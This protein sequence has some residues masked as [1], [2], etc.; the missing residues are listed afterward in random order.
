MNDIRFDD[1]VAIITGA[2]NGL[3]KDY[4]LSLSKLGAAVVVNDL[5]VDPV[6]GGGSRRPADAVVEEI[7]A[8]GGR[9]IASYDTV[10]TPEGG[11]AIAQSAL[12]AFGKVDILINN[13]AIMTTG[14]LTDV[15]KEDLDA[16]LAVHLCGSFYVTQPCFEVMQARGYG[17]LLFVSSN[18][19][20]FGRMGISAYAAAKAGVIG[21]MNV[22]A[23]EG[24]PYGIMSNAL[25]PSAF[26]RQSDAYVEDA[27]KEVKKSRATD[28]E[29]EVI[30]AAIEVIR[31]SMTPEFVTPMALYLCSE[32][33]QISHSTFSAVAGRY[34]R[35]FMGLTRGWTASDTAP[36]SVN[37]IASH[38]AAITD[39]KDFIIPTNVADE[40]AAIA[41][42]RKNFRR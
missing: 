20:T 12:D 5:G 10:A 16:N 3:G 38:M 25:L 15:R 33:C 7:R 26:T 23:S 39:T 32:A 6:R 30:N 21:L 9:A 22:V 27:A 18:G 35:S 36:P 8:A 2:G 40:F 24:A 42:D 14:L 13:A 28:Q 11:R 4:A 37:E 41:E 17:R 1:R 29:D 31:G 34:A 19:G